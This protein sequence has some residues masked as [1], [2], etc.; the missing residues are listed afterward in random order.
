MMTSVIV[1]LFDPVSDCALYHQL[2]LFIIRIKAVLD[3]RT[4]QC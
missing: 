3:F 4:F 2:H 1:E